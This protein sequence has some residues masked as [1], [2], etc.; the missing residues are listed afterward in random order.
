[1]DESENCWLLA[2]LAPVFL[3]PFTVWIGVRVLLLSYSSRAVRSRN[4]VG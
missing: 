1:M 2:R 4:R 3:A